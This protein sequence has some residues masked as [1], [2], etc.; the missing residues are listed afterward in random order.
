MLYRGH[1]QKVNGKIRFRGRKTITIGSCGFAL[2]MKIL[3]VNLAD[4]QR[5]L[6]TEESE[7][8]MLG[9]SGLIISTRNKNRVWLILLRWV[10]V[11]IYRL[12]KCVDRK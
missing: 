7:G 10:I 3:S 11:L 4:N 12:S 1:V 9:E 5:K 2:I 6:K 8:R